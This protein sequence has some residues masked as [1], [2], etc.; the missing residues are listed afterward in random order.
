MIPQLDTGRIVGSKSSNSI[1]MFTQPNRDEPQEAR[2]LLDCIPRTLVTHKDKTPMPSMEQ[3]KDFIGY[4]PFRSNLDLTDGYHNI[5]IHPDSVSES[6]FTCHMGKFD[7]LGMQQ[8][9]G[10]APATM[11]RAMNYLFREVKDPMIYLDDILIANH[12]YAENINTIRQ[13]LQIAKE[14]KLW[15]NRHKCQ[16]MPDKLA[17]LGDYL[18]VLGLEADPDKVH[19][20][21]QFP[22]SDT[23]TQLRRFLGM[24]PYL[25]QFCPELA[26]A[27]APLSELQGSTKKWKW[28][29]LHSH[30]FQTCKDLI[31][32]NKV[33]EPINPDPDQRIYLICDSSN[34]GL[35]G[36]IGQMQDDGIIK[37]ARFYSKKFNN[38]QMNYGITKKELLAIVDSVRH[39]RGVLQG[40]PITILTDHQP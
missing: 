24:V 5:R 39:F 16:F 37:P 3:I 32:S 33:L 7:S 28:T 14:N 11:M 36:C 15:F 34:I 12:T 19:S 22:K 25:R 35:S 13:V 6:T 26:A 38:A 4:R 18:T 40:H 27:A 21:Q 20:I 1:G 8:C 10:N 9:D 30:S 23:R 29:D 31:M 2:F 17:T